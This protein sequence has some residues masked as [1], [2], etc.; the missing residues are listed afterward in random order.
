MRKR[1]IPIVIAV[2]AV[3]LA[4]VAA[5]LLRKRAAPEPARLLPEADGYFYIN[6]K[7]V[8]LAGVI[9]NNPPVTHDS[10]YEEFVKQTGFQFER[11]LDEAAFAVHAPPRLVDRELPAAGD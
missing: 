7:P 10:D 6:L 5:V 1:T 8:R 9:G 4:I 11:D 3:A 2:L